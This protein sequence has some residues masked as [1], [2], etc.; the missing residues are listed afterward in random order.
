MYTGGCRDGKGC[1]SIEVD[2]RSTYKPP[3][4]LNNEK[5]SK[6]LIQVSFFISWSTKSKVEIFNPFALN[7]IN[8]NGKKDKRIEIHPLC[9]YNALK[10]LHHFFKQ[11]H[12]FWGSYL[13]LKLQKGFRSP[14]PR[15]FLP[16]TII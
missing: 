14:P 1:D 4:D 11:L 10:F 15:P 5:Y 2:R 7:V 13:T 9:I 12:F 3:L 8:T 6:S 16:I